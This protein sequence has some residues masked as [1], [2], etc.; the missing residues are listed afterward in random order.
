MG[1]VEVDQLDHDE[2]DQELLAGGMGERKKLSDLSPER[3][4][5]EIRYCYLNTMQL[6]GC[7]HN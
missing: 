5:Q 4:A 6:Q 1:N 7:I 2:F 3:A